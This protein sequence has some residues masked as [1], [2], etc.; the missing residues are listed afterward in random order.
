MSRVFARRLSTYFPLAAQGPSSAGPSRAATAPIAVRRRRA[1]QPGAQR[2]SPLLTPESFAYGE[3]VFPP[4]LEDQFQEQRAAGNYKGDEES[5]RAKFLEVNAAWR[6]RV[7]GG[8]GKARIGDNATSIPDSK[9]A[10]FAREGAERDS[11]D[12]AE[13]RNAIVGT[14]VYLPNIQIRLMRN[15]TPPGEAYDPTIATFRIPPSMTK[16]DLRSYLY[17]VYGLEVTFIRTDNYVA[18]THR[19]AGGRVAREK[20]SKKNYKRAI[21]GLTEPFH[22]PDD[23]EEMRAGTFGGLEEGERL[24]KIREEVLDGEY[25]LKDVEEYRKAQKMKMYKGWRWRAV[26]H[27]NAVSGIDQVS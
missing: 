17:S 24:A 4:K 20:G 8:H 12:G 3:Q 7:R 26:T 23:V 19:I 13:W 14:K 15:Y 18:P 10:Y 27:D 25:V 11:E 9:A 2:P 22:Y 1:E 21:V 16:T 5:A 6:S